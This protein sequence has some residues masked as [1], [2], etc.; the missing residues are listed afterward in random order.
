[1]DFHVSIIRYVFRITWSGEINYNFNFIWIWLNFFFTN[2]K[3]NK[4]LLSLKIHICRV[5]LN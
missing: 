3:P 1:M 2:N 4:Q 5:T